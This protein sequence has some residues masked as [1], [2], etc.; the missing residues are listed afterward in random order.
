MRKK[1]Y[2]INNSK[3][4]LNLTQYFRN[5]NNNL[6]NNEHSSQ[7]SRNVKKKREKNSFFII[8]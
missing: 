3:I 5:I 4:I 2:I 6:K 1:N 8:L 7:Y